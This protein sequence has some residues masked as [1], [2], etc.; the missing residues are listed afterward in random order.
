[1]A[2]PAGTARSRRPGSGA[3]LS[4]SGKDEPHDDRQ[5]AQC[6]DLPDPVATWPDESSPW[7]EA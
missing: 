3:W 6:E 1:M 4:G 7:A 2:R 5:L